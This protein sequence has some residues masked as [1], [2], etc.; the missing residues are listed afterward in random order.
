MPNFAST[1]NGAPADQLPIVR[2]WFGETPADPSHLKAL[3]A[4]YPAHGMICWPVSP[5]V[6]N[7][8]SNDPTLIEPVAM[9]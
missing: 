7:V 2:L 4:P 1:W 6:G 8:D 5:Q 9:M 3:L